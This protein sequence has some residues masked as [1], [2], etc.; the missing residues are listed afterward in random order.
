MPTWGSAG[1]GWNQP[2]SPDLTN[3]D[4]LP[5]RSRHILLTAMAETQEHQTN[6]MGTFQASSHLTPANIALAKASHMAKQKYKL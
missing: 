6:C 4:Y 1:I 3:V 2:G 5:P